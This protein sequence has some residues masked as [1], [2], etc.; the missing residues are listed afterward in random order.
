[1]TWRELWDWYWNMA[2]WSM[3]I[4]APLGLLF[5][6]GGEIYINFL[7][8]EPI[9]IKYACQYIND[10]HRVNGFLYETKKGAINDIEK[11]ENK[12][13]VTRHGASSKKIELQ[14]DEKIFV[15]KYFR[16]STLARIKII[17]KMYYNDTT[18]YRGWIPTI[19]LQ[20]SISSYAVPVKRYKVDNIQTAY[21]RVGSR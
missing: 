12:E 8:P 10:N 4:V 2:F 13:V 5:F 18:F 19:L 9:E 20:D 1:M 21:N 14:L 17:D 16:D 15:I 3:L 11:Y 6:L 7:E